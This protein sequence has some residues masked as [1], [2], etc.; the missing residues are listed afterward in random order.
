MALVWVV[1]ATGSHSELGRSSWL[2]G[3]FAGVIIVTFIAWPVRSLLLRLRS[4][5]SSK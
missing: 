3:V 1:F 4:V 2:A 5:R